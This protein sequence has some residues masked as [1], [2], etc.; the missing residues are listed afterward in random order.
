MS[1]SGTSVFNDTRDGRRHAPW[2]RTVTAVSIIALLA[3]QLAAPLAQA[4]QASPRVI[5][6]PNAPI[7][8]RPNVGSSANGTPQIDITAPSSGGISHNRF[9]QYD[10]DTRGV[11][12]NNATSGGTSVIGGTVNANP[13]LIGSGPAAIILNE[14]T[15]ST[16]SSLAGPTE[17][18]GRR[19]NVII[20]N[21]NGVG[22]AGCTFINTG[23]VTLSAAVP[24]PNYAT[25][26]VSYDLSRGGQVSV[27]G[28]G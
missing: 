9:R 12:L 1:K 8:F 18:F 2:R 5:T 19:A 14:V 28:A 24:L 13:N 4:Q 17:V 6:D 7:Q 15:G 26:A 22:C 25:G 11:I 23:T 27:S 21:P 10:V 3:G 20:A 16:A